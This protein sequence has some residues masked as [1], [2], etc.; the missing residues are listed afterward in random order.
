MFTYFNAIFQWMKSKITTSTSLEKE[1]SR[2]M[3]NTETKKQERYVI[4][5]FGLQNMF[6]QKE[7]CLGVDTVRKGS[8]M[9]SLQY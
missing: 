1:A 5:V 6:C 8:K 7:I 2:I 3:H 4:E 9:T